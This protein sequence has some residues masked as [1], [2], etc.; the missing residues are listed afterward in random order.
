M[1]IRT[2]IGYNSERRLLEVILLERI[3]DSPSV[4][5]LFKMDNPTEYPP[6]ELGQLPTCDVTHGIVHWGKPLTSGVLT[7]TANSEEQLRK[8]IEEIPSL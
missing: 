3:D 2:V 1:S 5:G 4:F 7:G 6:R 8:L